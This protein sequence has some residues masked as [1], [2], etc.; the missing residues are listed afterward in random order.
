MSTV[1]NVH[2]PAGMHYSLCGAR[3]VNEIDCPSCKYGTL[4]PKLQKDG[5][6]CIDCH[7]EFPES[8]VKKPK[9]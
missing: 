3:H 7:K 6:F 4:I 9:K 8:V 2:S 1:K 5:Y